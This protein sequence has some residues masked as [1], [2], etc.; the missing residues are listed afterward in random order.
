MEAGSEW[1]TFGK[2]QFTVFAPYGTHVRKTYRR[3]TYFSIMNIAQTS[4]SIIFGI[5]ESFEEP[6]STS[7][8]TSTVALSTITTNSICIDFV[9][10]HL[11]SL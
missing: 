4:R 10:V 7:T 9:H 3:A 5:G 11:V 6:S 2:I 1:A 8:S